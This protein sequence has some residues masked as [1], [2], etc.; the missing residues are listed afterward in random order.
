[1]TSEYP[2]TTI[3]GVKTS[4]ASP[5]ATAETAKKDGTSRLVPIE[6]LMKVMIVVGNRFRQLTLVAVLL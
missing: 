6:P 5:T 1:M 2:T 3:I 4:T